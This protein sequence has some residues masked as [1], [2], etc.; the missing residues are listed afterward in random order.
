MYSAFDLA[1]DVTSQAAIPNLDYV[2]ASKFESAFVFT[3]CVIAFL[4]SRQSSSLFFNLSDVSCE[5]NFSSVY[6]I[7]QPENAI[8][9]AIYLAVFIMPSRCH[10]QVH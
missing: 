5:S 3:D 10:Y 7:S 6:R 1:F 2:N 9:L 8:S 4:P